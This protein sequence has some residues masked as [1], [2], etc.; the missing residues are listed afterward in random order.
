[1]RR[2]IS[3]VVIFIVLILSSFIAIDIKFG[4]VKIVE[5]E[6]LYVNTTGN[7][8]AFTCIQ[9]AIDN[10]SDGDTVFVFSGTYY[11]NVVVNKTISLVGEDRNTTEINGWNDGDVVLITRDYVNITG[12]NC[13]RAGSNLEDAGIELYSVQNCKVL[14]NNFRFG[15][16]SGIRLYSSN[17]NTVEDNNISQ[18]GFAIYLKYSND[19]IVIRNIGYSNNHYGIFLYSSFGNNVTE[20]NVSNGDDYGIALS[21][22]NGNI[23][24]DNTA[25][26][27][28]ESGIYFLDSYRN[29]VFRNNI[30]NNLYGIK[31]WTSNYNNIVNNNVFPNNHDGIR[32]DYSD[33]N[34]VIDNDVLN[35]SYGIDI[36]RSDLNNILGNNADLNSDI[37]IYLWKSSGNNISNNIASNGVHGICLSDSYKNNIT[38]NNASHNNMDGIQLTRSINNCLKN[39]T[40]IDNGIFI[41][42]IN[43]EHWNT[44]NI[45][46]SNTVNG[47]PVYYWK[48]KT[49]GTIPKGAGQV[50]LANCTEII[51]ENQELGNGS[52]GV[53]LGYCS[54]N[55]ISNNS[56]PSN[57]WYGYYLWKSNSNTLA[58]NSVSHSGY[59]FFADGHGICLDSSNENV[60]IGNN[61]SNHQPG[62]GIY[63]YNSTNNTINTNILSENY[64]GIMLSSSPYNVLHGNIALNNTHYGIRITSS[65]QNN[66]SCNNLSRNSCGIFNQ[67]SHENILE[68]NNISGNNY[69]INFVGSVNNTIFHNNFLYNAFHAYDNSDNNFWDGDYPLG[70]NY[71][72]DYVGTDIFKGPYQNIPGSD[73]MGD[74]PY[75]TIH[76]G[77]DNQDNYPL[78]DNYTYEPLE[79]FTILKQGWNLISI[80][81]IQDNKN[82]Q[83]VLEMIDGY[84]DAV[85]WYDTTD[86]T[87]PWKHH[88]VDKPF[89]NDLFELNET[90]GFWIHITNPG[91]TIFLY[92]GTQSS[93]NQTIVLN[94]GWNLVGYPSATSHNR[95]VGLNNLQFGSDIDAIQWFNAATKTWH[96]MG[97]EDNFEIGMGYWVHSK[98]NTVWEVPL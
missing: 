37:G 23:I 42:G 10:A 54:N 15:G 26:S 43:L 71:W 92:N 83:K 96:F 86:I 84:Y 33:F 39:N 35:N 5:G 13:T 19:N 24:T 36:C 45:E 49:D 82:L 21:K 70:G 11:E 97:P 14:S 90:M 88:K 64:Y 50:I 61:A 40:M 22:S 41:S 31:L 28:K 91:D 7:G 9:D 65:N 2:K 74:T 53:E 75:T 76:G 87:D 72:S 66:V 16:Y 69:G 81:L 57:S 17:N 1:L 56:A 63:L 89:G 80:P 73:G 46:T 94:E 47:K 55:T 68:G 52:V 44:H 95:T 3:S 51:V 38:Y 59:R 77:Y 85:Q 4:L 29:N 20:N 34:N 60:I 18:R 25:F 58:G 6:T 27:N 93:E 48:D 98:V 12:F 79:N 62:E 67:Y 30:S 78:M 32:L 8:G